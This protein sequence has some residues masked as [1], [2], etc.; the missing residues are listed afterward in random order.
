MKHSCYKNETFPSE[1]VCVKCQQQVPLATS[2]I[3][4]HRSWSQIHR[5]SVVSLS[6]LP[7]PCCT[8]VAF[9][10]TTHHSNATTR[11]SYILRNEADFNHLPSVW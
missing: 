9:T 3:T 2:T 6:R 4:D 11:E 5:I 10:Q 1:N 8:Q 7:N